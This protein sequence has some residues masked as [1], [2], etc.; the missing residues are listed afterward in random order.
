[1]TFTLPDYDQI[2]T[3]GLYTPDRVH[4]LQFEKQS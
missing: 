1:M 4:D 3:V 2:P